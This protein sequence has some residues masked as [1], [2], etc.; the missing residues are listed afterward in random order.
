[1]NAQRI[2]GWVSHPEDPEQQNHWVCEER[3]SEAQFMHQ[4]FVKNGW[5]TRHLVAEEKPE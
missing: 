1:M 4:W 2:Y 5:D 3:P